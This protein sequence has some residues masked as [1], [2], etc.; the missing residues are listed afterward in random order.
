MGNESFPKL[1]SETIVWKIIHKKIRIFKNMKNM[2]LMA[3][4]TKQGI[5]FKN[6]YKRFEDRKLHIT[7]ISLDLNY[8][9]TGS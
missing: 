7:V 5:D 4:N 3:F 2:V 6:S 9:Q 1:P 8:C